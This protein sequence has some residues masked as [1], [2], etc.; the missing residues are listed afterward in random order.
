MVSA[1]HPGAS[2]R[3]LSIVRTQDTAF[4][5]CG[6]IR[7]AEKRFH[8][9]GLDR[10]A[11]NLIEIAELSAHYSGD[12]CAEDAPPR[13]L[14]RALRI[15]GVRPKAPPNPTVRESAIELGR[16]VGFQP[17]KRQPLP[18]LRKLWSAWT[19]FALAILL[20]R[21]FKTYG[22]DDESSVGN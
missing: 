22:T 18:G 20:Y 2:S 13:I 1:V 15:N 19:I 14:R 3:G 6:Q 12:A 10:G 21:D 8:A 16:L 4:S 5:Q 17:L 11:L 7:N 9:S